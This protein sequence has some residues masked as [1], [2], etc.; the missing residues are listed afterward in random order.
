MRRWVR[1]ALDAGRGYGWTEQMIRDTVATRT[2]G[3]V[4]LSDLRRAIEW[5]HARG[6][7]RSEENEDSGAREYYITREGIAKEQ[8][9]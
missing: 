5:N 9:V 6:Y 8:V 2:P 4:D 7:L 3:E 1:E